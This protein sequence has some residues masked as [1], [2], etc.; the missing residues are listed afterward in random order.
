[1]NLQKI[2]MNSVFF[3]GFNHYFQLKIDHFNLFALLIAESFYTVLSSCYVL[4]TQI[5]VISDT[6]YQ[7]R[8][9]SSFPYR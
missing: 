8:L 4:H 2:N 9:Q 6:R 5:N 1:M 3:F 7:E